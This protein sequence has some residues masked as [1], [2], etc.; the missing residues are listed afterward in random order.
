[1][2]LLNAKYFQSILFTTATEEVLAKFT[3]QFL[4]QQAS[5]KSIFQ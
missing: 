2:K 5:T 3:I 1:M 4:K